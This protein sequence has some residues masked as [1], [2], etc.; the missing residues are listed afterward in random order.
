MFDIKSYKTT[1]DLKKAVKWCLDN[2]TFIDVID[3]SNYV[4]EF[5]QS[6]TGD[7]ISVAFSDYTVVVILSE[8]L[9]M[10]QCMVTGTGLSTIQ[11]SAEDTLKVMN[12]LNETVFAWQRGMIEEITLESLE[13]LE[14][15]DDSI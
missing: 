9:K 14:L 7:T 13:A 15:A 6:A 2:D 3:E 10:I 8:K 11:L 12:A 4:L 5:K 1:A